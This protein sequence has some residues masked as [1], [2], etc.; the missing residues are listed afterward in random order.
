MP[1]HDVS[2]SLE[3][4]G[5]WLSYTPTWTSDG[6]Q[7][8]LG[9]GTLSGRYTRIGNLVIA[10]VS[11]TTGS[12]TTYGTGVYSFSY[13][14]TEDSAAGSV[15]GY[16]ICFDTSGSAIY[17]VGWRNNVPTTMAAPIAFVGP[18]VPFTWAT[19]DQFQGSISY[20]AVG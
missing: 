8:S 7:P 9:N 3:N 4:L 15:N 5:E 11:L 19:G 1:G 13:P 20:M 16:G 2:W 14:F 6:T 18:T 12:T 10:K 17:N